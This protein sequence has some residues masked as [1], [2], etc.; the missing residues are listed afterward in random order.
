[1]PRFIKAD[2]IKTASTAIQIPSG[3][4]AS[5]PDYPVNG[6]FRYN[7][8]LSRF[9]IY[10]NGWKQVAINGTVSIVKDSFTGDGATVAF[11]LSQ[12]PV[13]T[14]TILVFVGNV[15]QNP[16]DAF[17][18]FNNVITFTNAPPS[19]QTV[20]VFHNFASTDAN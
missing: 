20:I 12:T 17:T 8:D 9:E 4:T 10:Y 14:R 7:T 3:S 18:L 15:Q 13:S 6:Q 19:G 11:S 1:M 2:Q 16:D 5:R